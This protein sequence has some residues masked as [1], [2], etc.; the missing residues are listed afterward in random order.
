MFRQL[1][2]MSQIYEY[3]TRSEL[4]QVPLQCTQINYV[5]RKAWTALRLKCWNYEVIRGGIKKKNQVFFG[6]FPK[7]GGGGLAESKISLAEKTEIFLD[8][9]SYWRGGV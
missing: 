6:V 7:G 4:L 5:A 8:F 3:V 1:L 9:F 2:G